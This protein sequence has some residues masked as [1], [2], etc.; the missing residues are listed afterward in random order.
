MQFRS[1]EISDPAFERDGLRHITLK[2]RALQQRADIT[3][4]V[5]ELDLHAST[6]IVLLLHGVYGSHWA[7]AYKGGAHR[8]AQRLIHAQQIRPM[9]LAMPSDGLWGDGSGYVDHGQK[10]FERWIV[11]EVPLFIRE[12]YNLAKKASPLFIAGLSMGG[13]GALRLGAKYPSIFSGISGLSSITDF[14]DWQ[15]FMEEEITGLP[16]P[17]AEQT[18]LHFLRQNPA[19]LPPIRFDCGTEDR[20]LASNRTLH[21]SLSEAGIQHVYEEFPGGHSWPYWTKGLERSLLFFESIEVEYPLPV[22]PPFH[23]GHS[24]P[25]GTIAHPPDGALP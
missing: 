20:L 6:P 10:D 24:P 7:W 14:S 2:S 4:F 18:A 11:E 13:Y 1:I 16:I 17:E 5:P 3:L 23:R 8:A 25:F 22:K 21:E 12:Q 15:T 9:I 19:T